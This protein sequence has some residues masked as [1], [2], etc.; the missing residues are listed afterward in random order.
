MPND[1][2]IQEL[3]KENRRLFNR[4]KHLEEQHRLDMEEI[5]RLRR[6]IDSLMESMEAKG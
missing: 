5:S 6:W 3:R 4:N 1:N 2:E